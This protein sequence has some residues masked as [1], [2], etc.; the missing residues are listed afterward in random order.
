MRE[1]QEDNVVRGLFTA[2]S[3]MNVQQNRLDEIANNLANVDLNGYKKD[4]AIQK[5]FPEMLMRRMNDDGV[6]TFP[7]GSVDTTPM[8]GTLGTGV[9]TNEVY[10]N[11]VQ[12]PLKQTEN[13]FDVAMEG[14]G[15][16]TVATPQGERLTR[17]GAFLVNSDGFL[18]TKTG[19]FVLGESGP[20]KLK[21][22]NFVID[23]DGTVWQNS[24]FA[25]DD[26]RLV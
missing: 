2:A 4:T 3:G 14:G 24:T 10:T 11:F 15:F 5:A 7:V 8:V 22:N 19:D 6:Y 13:D 23:Q 21:K 26:K 1:A 20:I 12:G 18:V 17:N 9:E 16:M 25:A